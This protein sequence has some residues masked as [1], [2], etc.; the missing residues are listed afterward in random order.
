VQLVIVKKN[1]GN[2]KIS[3]FTNFIKNCCLV[4]CFI[5]L[6]VFCHVKITADVSGLA[7]GHKVVEAKLLLCVRPFVFLIT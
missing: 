5:F 1:G 3:L 4:I 2:K 7:V 6:V